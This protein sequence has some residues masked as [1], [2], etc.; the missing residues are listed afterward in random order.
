MTSVLSVR[1]KDWCWSW[2]PNTLVTWC[3]ELTHLK[4]PW[5]WERLKAGGEADNRG[6]HG[7]MASPPRWTWVWVYSGR[8]CW[9]ER[10]GM[11]Q[12]LGLQRVV[13]DWETELNWTESRSSF[14]WPAICSL[15][16]E[17]ATV[18]VETKGSLGRL[19]LS[20]WFIGSE[21]SCLPSFLGQEF[22]QE[23]CDL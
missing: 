9:T 16:C 6:C 22:Q 13:H 19:S 1:W 18:R 8:W 20:L 11:L 14:G 7:W 3:K 2:N 12:F 5:C 23:G 4:R 17:R 10:P 15:A 21:Y